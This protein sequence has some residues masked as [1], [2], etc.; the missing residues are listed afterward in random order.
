MKNYF[1]ST[2]AI[3]LVSSF[4]FTSCLDLTSGATDAE[5]SL[6]Q[7][8]AESMTM[9]LPAM[10][11]DFDDRATTD[12]LKEETGIVMQLNQVDGEDP[13]FVIQDPNNSMRY[14]ACNMP[15]ALKVEG[16]KVTFD[17]EKKQ[18]GDNERWYAHPIKL[19]VIHDAS[20]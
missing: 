11:C 10:A 15:D 20:K 3:L 13:A 14:V 18:V 2:I 16:M 1:K 5:S 19:T 17:A 6:K 4:S 8:F 7:T 12:I 9:E